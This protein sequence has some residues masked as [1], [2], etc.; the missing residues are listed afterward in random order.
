MANEK[1]KC[2]VCGAIMNHHADKLLNECEAETSNA[3]QMIAMYQ[4][5]VCGA[6]ASRTATMNA[7]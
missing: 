1:I 2:P 3:C 4:C 6:A 5:P 7:A